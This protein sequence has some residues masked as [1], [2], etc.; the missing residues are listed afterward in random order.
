[1]A[2]HCRPSR[3]EGRDDEI[4]TFETPKGKRVELMPLPLETVVEVVP[5]VERFQL[6]QTTPLTLQVRL[7][8]SHGADDVQVW[9]LVKKCLR[10]Y[11]DSQGLPTVSIESSDELP[12]CSAVSA[13][14]RHVWSK[15]DSHQLPKEVLA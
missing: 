8:A 14:F 13:K 9:E 7:E 10:A 2:I 6:I 5:G 12:Q 11:L 3:V 4:L 15:W 1:M